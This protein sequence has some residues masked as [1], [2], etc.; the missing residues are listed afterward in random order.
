MYYGTEM[1]A[2]NFAVK[3]FGRCSRSQWNKICRNHRYTGGGIQYSPS[4]V[5]L[6]FLVCCCFAITRNKRLWCGWPCQKV[7]TATNGAADTQSLT[8]TE[9]YSLADSGHGLS[10]DSDHSRLALSTFR[11]KLNQQLQPRSQSPR[12]RAQTSA[13]S[14]DTGIYI[15]ETAER[16]AGDVGGRGGVGPWTAA[17]SRPSYGN[18]LATG[19]ANSDKLSRYKSWQPA[20]TRSSEMAESSPSTTQMKRATPVAAAQL[21]RTSGRSVERSLKNNNEDSVLA[22]KNR[23]SATTSS[24]P[25]ASP[26]TPDGRRPARPPPSPRSSTVQSQRRAAAVE[27]NLSP[28]ASSTDANVSDLDSSTSGSFLVLGPYGTSRLSCVS[29][30]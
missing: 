13:A 2:L 10:E 4:R 3:I 11:P 8:S 23:T 14:D 6:D 16:R 24:L 30:L 22:S 9:D 29:E 15:V 28:V 26:G 5:K 25:P 20:P 18:N 1:N 7:E 19:C 12:T 21:G 27:Q 17:T